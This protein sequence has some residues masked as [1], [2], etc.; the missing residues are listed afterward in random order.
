MKKKS[1]CPMTNDRPSHAPGR[2]RSFARG[3]SSI[4]IR[5]SS[6]ALLVLPLLAADPTNAPSARLLRPLAL[7]EAVDIALQQNSAI[8]KGKADLEAAHGVVVQTRAIALPRVN[9]SSQYGAN[10]DSTIDRFQTK[11]GGG[12]NSFFSKA[13]DYADQRWSAGIRISQSIFEGGRIE[14]ARRSARLTREQSLLQHQS[15]VA[16]TIRDV[17]VAYYAALMAA[18]QIMVQE[19]SVTLLEQELADTRRRHEAGTV[20]QFNVLRA[21]VEVANARPRLIRARNA[22]RV[23]KATL[24]QL[25]GET[26]PHD[27]EDLPLQLTDKLE[28]TP[29]EVKLSDA[30]QQSFASRTELGALRKAEKLRAENIVVARA[31][32]QPSVQ[33]FAGYG[34]KSSSFSRDLT[35]ELHGWEAGAQ[36]SWNIFDGRL[37]EGRV[38]EAEALHRR[39][40]EDITDVTRRIELEVRTAWSAFVE[41]RE[42][43]ESQKKVQE[44]AAEALRLATAR[45]AAG[46]GTQLEV[47]NAQTALTEARTTQVQAMHDYAVARARL[48]RAV[49]TTLV[50]GKP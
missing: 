19:A 36:L 46:S 20:P 47:L 18:Q 27:V 41:A 49:G 11:G 4:V 42:V 37:T 14:S 9:I 50:T 26:V 25:L 23:A 2:V 45:A 21:E 7:T 40:L 10:E 6:F 30:L 38:K 1:H 12:S 43:L 44:S 29:V 24:A 35:D 32:N 16:D 13:F 39:A 33:I 22:H 15:V 31:G 5:S 3:L 8:L 48:E 17:R 28:A 34:A